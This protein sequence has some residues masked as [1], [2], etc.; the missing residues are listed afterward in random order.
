M[1]KADL[2]EPKPIVWTIAGSD[3]GGG[4]GIQADLA[5]MQ[6]LGCHACSVISTITAQSSV[7]VSLVEGVSEAMLLAQLNTLLDDLPPKAIKIGLL[8]DQAQLLLVANWLRETLAVYQAHTEQFVPVILDPVMFAS[9]GDTLSTPALESLDFSC[10]KG[11]LT[12]ITPNGAELSVL[13]GEG[14]DES[15]G[16]T[17]I[18]ACLLA[19]QQLAMDLDCAVLAKGGDKGGTWDSDWAHDIFVCGQVPEVSLDHQNSRFLL[20]GQR[21]DTINNHGTGCTLSSA[22]AAT[23]ASGFVLHDAIVLAKAYV[24]A[25]LKD[26]EQLGVGPGVLARMGWPSHLS[27]FPSILKL[28]PYSLNSEDPRQYMTAALMASRYA[29]LNE[30]RLNER[31]ANKLT[32]IDKPFNVIEGPLG[33]YPVVDDVDMLASLLAAGTQTIQL[34]IKCTSEQDDPLLEEKIMQAVALGQQY[35]AR[36]FINDHWQLAIKH[37]AYGVHLGQEDLAFV[38]LPA[39]SEANIALGV[40]SHSYFELLLASQLAPSY[41]ALGHIFPTTTKVMPSLPQGLNKLSCYVSLMKGHYP[42]VAIGGIDDDRL[43]Q[44][45]ATGV[46][47]I[48]V[49]RAITQASSP[50]TAFTRLSQR[51]AQS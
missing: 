17:N 36:V 23:M 40:S 28:P 25:G 35:E 2:S 30:L 49:V 1:V 15:T 46:D 20:T 47:D 33:L 27:D 29:H 4:A 7:A 21:I 24:S 50:A 45:K 18:A 26:S 13:A 43:E 9:C 32:T 14:V 3:S 31:V 38:D 19:A 12:L 39:L 51:W 42:L 34:R 22:I 6:D 44:V 37:G 11:L 48:A 41:L 10:F 16:L 5:C 8:S